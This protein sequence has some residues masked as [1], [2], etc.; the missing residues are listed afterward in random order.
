MRFA[1][2][3][4]MLYAAAISYYGIISLV[5]LIALALSISSY[6]LRSRS[7][8]DAL[9]QVLSAL[10]P[11]S[12]QTFF[13]AAKV[14][15]ATS[16]WAMALYI[17]GLVWAGA[18]LFECIERVINA[19]WT[20]ADRAYHVRKAIGMTI[21]IAVGI[22]M[23]ASVAAGAAWATLGQAV[24]LPIP[25]WV[26]A[27]RLVRRLGL[28]VPVITSILMLTLLYKLLPTRRVPWRSALAGGI[29]AGLCWEIT[30]LVFGIF[31]VHSGARYGALYG[32]L[33]NVVIIML[34]IHISAIILILGAH[35]GRII[36]ER[37]VSPESQ[38]AA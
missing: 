21:V 9:Y 17:F 7:A 38:P 1:Q 22:L 15:S 29:F 11:V 12:A 27:G 3:H 31:V 13:S 20:G 24:N 19:V 5:P 4:H 37:M 18:Y 28:L 36:E 8:D 32:S 25:E 26:H 10:F 30:K 6:F 16:P 34:W 23:L 14:I 2:Q 35:I 33:A